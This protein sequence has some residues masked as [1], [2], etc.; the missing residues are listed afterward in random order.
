MEVVESKE[1]ALSNALVDQSKGVY[2]LM[3]SRWLGIIILKIRNCDAFVFVMLCFPQLGRLPV[4]F[5]PIR[6]NDSL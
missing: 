2:Y 4:G 6:A 5:P 3:R 1:R